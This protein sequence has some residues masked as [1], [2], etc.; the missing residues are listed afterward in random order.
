MRAGSVHAPVSNTPYTNL[1]D[2]RMLKPL[3]YGDL[4]FRLTKDKIVPMGNE[5]R[6]CNGEYCDNQALYNNESAVGVDVCSGPRAHV[7]GS[8]LQPDA[9][10]DGMPRYP[11]FGVCSMKKGNPW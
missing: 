9:C 6:F 1:H 4:T 11:G 10:C 2:S 3:S 5:I 8:A 7:R